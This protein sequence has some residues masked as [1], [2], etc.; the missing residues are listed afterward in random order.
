MYENFDQSNRLGARYMEILV[1][2]VLENGVHKWSGTSN[3]KTWTLFCGDAV[4]LSFLIAESV[5][6]IV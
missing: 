5:I 4:A 6:W 3:Q 1:D 2:E